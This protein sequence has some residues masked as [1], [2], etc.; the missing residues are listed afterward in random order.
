MEKIAILGCGGA[1]KSTLARQLGSR[2][3][4]P[5]IHLDA[6]FWRPGWV[7]TPLDE[8]IARQSQIVAGPRWIVD[9]NYGATIEIRLAA[10]DT[11]IYLDFPAGSAYAASFGGEFSMPAERARTWGRAVGRGSRWILFNGSGTTAGQIVPE[12][13]KG[14][15]RLKRTAKQSS[16]CAARSRCGGSSR[17]C[18]DWPDATFSAPACH[19]E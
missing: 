17:A 6:E 12:S 5:V 8:E 7:M 1:G 3:G 4:L 18:R 13:C 9:G 16:V 19:T 10:A 11:V 14:S 15:R 2:L